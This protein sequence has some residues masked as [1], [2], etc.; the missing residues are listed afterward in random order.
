VT[1][2][3]STRHRIACAA[4]HAFSSLAVTMSHIHEG[5]S[6]WVDPVYCIFNREASPIPVLAMLSVE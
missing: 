1:H 6:G 3:S 2:T 4:E 5:W